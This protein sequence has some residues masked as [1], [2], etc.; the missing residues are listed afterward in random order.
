MLLQVRHPIGPL[1]PSYSP[2]SCFSETKW[3]LISVPCCISLVLLS[4]VVCCTKKHV[5]SLIVQPD[6]ATFS[7]F[8]PLPEFPVDTCAGRSVIP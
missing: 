5:E 7:L 2:S 8:H 3:D 6:P 1:G 4:S